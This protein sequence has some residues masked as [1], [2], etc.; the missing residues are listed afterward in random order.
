MARKSPNAPGLNSRNGISLIEMFRMCPD[1]A[2]AEQWFIQ[3]R[4]PNGI[5]CPRCGSDNVNPKGKHPTMPHRCRSC[6]RQFSVKYG[7]VMQGSKLGYQVWAIACY[8]VTTNL[9]GISSMKLH[10]DLNITQKSAWH[11]AHRIRKTW[12]CHETKNFIGGPVEAD[13][14]YIGGLEKNKHT[15][16]KAKLGRGPSSKTAVAGIK[17]RKTGE[18]RA[19]VVDRTDGATLKGFVNEHI[20]K[21]ATVFTDDAKAYK[22]LENHESVKHSVSEYVN[23]QAHTNGV[24]SF[25]ALLK[26]GYHGTYH[27]MSPKHLDRYISEFA[28]R[29]NVR[30]CDTIEQLER[31]AVGMDGKRLR[32]KDLI[33]PTHRKPF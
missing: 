18:I 14:T 17:D 24:E 23:G 19:K 27:K 21:G 15:H 6:R 13:E 12:E 28:G 3:Q 16:K 29:H 1:D 4:W 30:P 32:Y 22:G 10:R 31:M 11:L 20:E 5:A 25:W 2:T 9:K 8:L 33:K 7:T 26:R